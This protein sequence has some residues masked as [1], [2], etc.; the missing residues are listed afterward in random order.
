MAKNSENENKHMTNQKSQM[1]INKW[2]ITVYKWKMIKK[3]MTNWPQEKTDW[4]QWRIAF[5]AN[6]TKIWQIFDEHLTNDKQQL[7][8]QNL[9]LKASWEPFKYYLA[10]FLR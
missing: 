2:R 9:F 4:Q 7:T 5:D 1:I 6:L 8:T 10:D 3:Q